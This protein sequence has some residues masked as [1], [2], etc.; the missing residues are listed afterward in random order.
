MGH[1]RPCLLAPGPGLLSLQCRAVVPQ[2]GTFSPLLEPASSEQSFPLVS[3]VKYVVGVRTCLDVSDR[4][5]NSDGLIQTAATRGMYSLIELKSPGRGF[6]QC[7][8]QEAQLSPE[9][10]T[11]L[12]PGLAPERPRP[13]CKVQMQA[14]QHSVLPVLPR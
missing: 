9:P 1:P 10:S 2:P 5:L 12:G 3:W 11:W 14:S 4:K 8:N 13:R 7:Y 6:V